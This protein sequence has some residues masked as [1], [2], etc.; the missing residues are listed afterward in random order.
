MQNEASIMQPNQE[1]D[2]AFVF[3]VNYSCQ[4]R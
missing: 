1:E 2:T 4:L 3:S